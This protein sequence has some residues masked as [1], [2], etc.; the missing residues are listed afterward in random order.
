M[1]AF[2]QALGTTD[3]RGPVQPER[4]RLL[5]KQASALYTQGDTSLND[6]V[7]DVLRDQQGL[8]P[9]HVRRVVEF[10]NQFAFEEAFQKEAGD[11]RVVNF[12]GGPASPSYVMKEL[13][14][15]PTPISDSAAIS[16]PN[17]YVPGYDGA[18]AAFGGNE[19]TASAR[20][21]D[22]QYENPQGNVVELWETLTSAR[23]QLSGDLSSMEIMYDQAVNG[24][25]KEARQVLLDG[26]S[27]AD[28]SSVVA[29]AAPNPTFVKLALKVISQKMEEHGVPAS[30]N[31]T[32]IASVRMANPKHPLYRATEEFSKVASARYT[33]AAALEKVSDELASVRRLLAEVIQ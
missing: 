12:D 26:H 4:L 9:E 7:V 6:A 28:V 33:Y 2:E 11:H 21:A 8:G 14:Q 25:Y 23:N 17:G 1:M 15:D 5:G 27:P 24:L 31:V 3:S 19:K 18:M 20:R 22:Y 32:K 10:A 29:S 13:R 16:P 30:R